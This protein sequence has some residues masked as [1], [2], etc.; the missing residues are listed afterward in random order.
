MGRST[1]S[2]KSESRPP[3]RTALPDPF[4]VDSRRRSPS[5]LGDIL[6]GV[7]EELLSIRVGRH[8]VGQRLRRPGRAARDKSREKRVRGAAMLGNRKGKL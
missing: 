5:V 6:S 8:Q 7:V 4:Q 3:T 1:G 2:F